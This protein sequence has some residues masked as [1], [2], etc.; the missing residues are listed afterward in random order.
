MY[1]RRRALGGAD[2]Q[3]DAGSSMNVDMCRFRGNVDSVLDNRILA[4][5]K[6]LTHGT[7][8]VNERSTRIHVVDIVSG[9]D[10]DGCVLRDR[11][12]MS[13]VDGDDSI[14]VYG[15]SIVM[16]DRR[17]HI[18]LCVNDYLFFTRSVVHRHL[19]VALAF[20]GL[21][22]HAADSLGGGETEWGHGLFVVDSAGDQRAVHVSLKER[23]HYF[24]AYAWYVDA[25]E[26]FAS[27][28]LTYSDPATGV[29]VFFAFSVP[30]K[31]D[32]HST[33]FVR[34]DLFAWRSDD[35]GCLYAG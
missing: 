30:V 3:L 5:F 26:A 21:G 20:V 2:M 22:L 25:A 10:R 27:V 4:V 13:S 29:F 31:L 24:F 7:F 12:G 18:V 34:V 19:V 8:N 32:L 35:D 14:V 11:F 23:N 6:F 17:G 9:L 15:L 28:D 1:Q 33:V 16:F